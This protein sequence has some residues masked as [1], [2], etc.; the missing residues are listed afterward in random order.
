MMKLNYRNEARSRLAAAKKELASGDDARFRYAALELRMAME[1]L[2]YDRALA[3][4]DEFPPSEYQTWQPR[5]VMSILLE[6]DPSAD[7]SFGLAMGIEEE[8][9]VQSPNMEFVGEERVLN[10]VALR[11][12]YDALGSYLHLPSMKHV[13]DGKSVDFQRL[14][15]RCDELVSLID[16]ALA[17]RI[18]NFTGFTE[19]EACRVTR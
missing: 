3:F 2:T 4:K 10:M 11:K 19:F 15:T 1:A 12:H 13:I 18:F 7:A 8:Y 5:K 17:S 6:I 14:R 16:E 9:G